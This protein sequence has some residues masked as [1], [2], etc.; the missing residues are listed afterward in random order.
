MGCR[1]LRQHAKSVAFERIN[2]ILAVTQKTTNGF[3]AP[4]RAELVAEAY[5][6]HPGAPQILKCAYGIA[7][8]LDKTPIYIY[9][10]EL[11]V[12]TLGCDKKG[13]PVHPEFGLN[14]V[15]DE[16]RDGLMDYSE[17]R[18]HDYFRYTRETQDR[19]EALRDFWDGHTV[20]DMTNAMLT[21]DVL[22]G[23]HAGKGSS[24]PSLISAARGH[25]GLDYER[26]FRPLQGHPGINPSAYGRR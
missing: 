3:V 21:D 13:A 8:V 16:M 19:L 4:D 15:V 2:K 5:K 7:N 17:Q 22:K 25:L 20:E 23:S 12:G 9:P 6:A 1:H 26:L 11:I 10:A 14:W 18:T 24:L